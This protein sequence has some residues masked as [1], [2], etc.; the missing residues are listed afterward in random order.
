VRWNPWRALRG[1]PWLLLRWATLD[2]A[3]GLL[4][5]HGDHRAIVL[6]PRLGRRARSAVLTHEL[7]HDERSLFYDA[8]TPLPLVAKEVAAVEGETCRRL[9]P[10]WI[11]R[12]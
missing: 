12:R 8:A 9:V 5:D 11:W 6:D 3:A 4:V 2:R 7:V 1:R 10:P